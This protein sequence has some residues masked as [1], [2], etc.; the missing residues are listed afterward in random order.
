MTRRMVS[1]LL[2][3][4]LL[5]VLLCPCA[6]AAPSK[7]ESKQEIYTYLTQ[8]MNCSRAVACGIMANI[9]AVSGYNPEARNPASGDTI[10]AY[11]LCQWTADRYAALKSFD[12]RYNTVAAQ[13]SFLRY[14]L[15]TGEAKC[16]PQI[17]NQEDSATGA[18]NAGVLFARLFLRISQYYGDM[19]QYAM[20]GGIART[21]YEELP[22]DDPGTTPADPGTTSA[23]P[24]TGDTPSGTGGFLRLPTVGTYTDGMFRDV[25]ANAWY[26]KGVAGAV[27]FGLMKGYEGNLFKPS[28]NVT[29][30]ETIT[31]AARLNSIY[32][33]GKDAITQT[34]GNQWYAP[35]VE[36]AV[37]NGIVKADTRNKTAAEMNQSAS[38]AQV[39]EIIANALPASALAARNTVADDAIPD[40]KTASAY[41]P[42]VYK[43][44]R[45]GILNGGGEKGAFLP[46]N[47]ITRAEMAT[48]MTRMADTANRVDVVL[49]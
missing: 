35:Y 32:A 15:L 4:S 16:W 26:Q 28:G 47:A 33:N 5:C 20:I 11:G 40:V 10:N 22:A 43:L 42:A 49:K 17:I 37:A 7:E 19:D 44:Y 36:Y 48:I 46:W 31:M 8:N 14:E 2:A 25:A 38:R 34:G 12:T 27:R 24:G 39:A 13:M 9:E 30:A 29:L 6:V 18:Y 3:L 41:G 21:L 1:L 45:A 23:N